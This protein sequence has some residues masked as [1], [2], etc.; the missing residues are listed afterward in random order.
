MCKIKHP[1]LIAFSIPVVALMLFVG[2]SDSSEDKL[3][4][5][6]NQPVILETKPIPTRD[7]R[8]CTNDEFSKLQT[9]SN[10][11]NKADIA[12]I[13]KLGDD[14][15]SW[16]KQT[17]LIQLA[18][19]AVRSCDLIEFYHSQKPCKKTMARSIIN[20]EAVNE[21]GY[22]VYRIKERCSR[23]TTY[24]KKFNLRPNSREVQ[25]EVEVKPSQPVATI[26][27]NSLRECTSDEFSKLNQY[28]TNLTKATAAIE[29]LGAISNWKYDSNAIQAA[30]VATRTC[31]AAIQY[32]STSPCKK[33]TKIYTES[34]LKDECK[35][36]R[37]YY[38]D[39]TQRQQDLIMPNANLM[40]DTTIFSNRIFNVGFS[41]TTY[42]I[43]VLSNVGNQAI[44]Y[45]RQ[46]TLVTAAR[47]YPAGEENAQMFIL[48]TRE[49]L[50]L[51][52]YGL[53]FPTASTSLNEVR[54][55]LKS[56]GLDIGLSY[57]LK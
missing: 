48:Q 52:C 7:L 18:T 4:T 46:K 53:S 30:T 44:Q 22:D 56:K 28:R 29:K 16:T 51:E 10:V 35:T 19:D 39:F 33:I 55:I 50:K 12:I 54:R 38:Y 34:L 17:D 11:L 47:A 25:P 20:P 49:G 14:S 13:N 9:W 37:S 43:C 24:L 45:N 5:S 6:G 27:T 31:E 36:T 1:T 8:E 42:D 2:C 40:L 26:N 15:K 41:S 23:V 57:E 3:A 21:R 32:H